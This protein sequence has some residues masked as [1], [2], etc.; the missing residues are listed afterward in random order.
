MA[1]GYSKKTADRMGSGNLYKP[2]IAEA[3]Q[4]AVQTRS[5][6]NELKG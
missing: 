4:K 3:T 6:R 1:A 5:E 2:Q